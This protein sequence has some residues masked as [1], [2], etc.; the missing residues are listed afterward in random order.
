MEK[1]EEKEK[2]KKNKITL[3]SYQKRRNS[4]GKHQSQKISVLRIKTA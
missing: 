3:S 2:R 4:D 1:M